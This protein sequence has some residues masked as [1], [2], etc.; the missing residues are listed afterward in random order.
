M[1]KAVFTVW[2]CTAQ[3]LSYS[4]RKGPPGGIVGLP[5]PL[6]PL[7]ELREG[8]LGAGQFIQPG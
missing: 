3:P 4:L 7:W 6:I 8:Q 2:D 1:K 5:S